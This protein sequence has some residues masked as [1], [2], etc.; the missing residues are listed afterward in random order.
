MT[1]IEIKTNLSIDEAIKR[2][3]NEVKSPSL[4]QKNG[5]L[6][7]KVSQEKISVYRV[8]T[9]LHFSNFPVFEG[10]LQTIDGKT[11]LQGKWTTYLYSKILMIISYGMLLALLAITTCIDPFSP[12]SIIFYSMIIVLFLFSRKYKFKRPQEDKEWII[13]CFE[14]ILNT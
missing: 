4:F 9:F 14:Y 13:K 1:I 2:L 6:M 11:T 8:Y 12:I 3:S 5:S 7:G 10:N